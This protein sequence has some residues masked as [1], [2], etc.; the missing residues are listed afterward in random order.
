ML[1]VSKL[2]A[3]YGHCRLIS[4]GCVKKKNN[5]LLEIVMKE[6]LRVPA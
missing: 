4:F 3:A 6:G 2:H 1:W 5:F